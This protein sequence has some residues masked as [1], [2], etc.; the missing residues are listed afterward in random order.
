ME[1][2]VAVFEDNKML[3]ESLQQLIN[4]AEGMACTGAFPDANKLLHHMHLANPDVVMMDINMPGMSG[5]EAVQ[6]I[7]EKFP[8]VHILMQTVFDDNDKIFAAICAGASGY[9]L[10]KTSPQKMIEAIHE[11]YL[12]GAPM[13]ASVAVKVLQMFRLQKTEKTEFI[14]LSER[15]KEILTLLVKGKSYKAV[16]AEC[17]ISIDTV[18]THVRHIY[19]KLHVHSK[20]EAVAK[21]INQKLV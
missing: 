21:A 4:N 5:I 15:E 2:K 11:T 10:K 12:G 6:L 17:F 19:E 14:D 13:T 18:S 8:Q 16:A 3:R 20:S 7:K 1:I 9:M